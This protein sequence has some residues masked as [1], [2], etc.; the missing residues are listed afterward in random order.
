M[1]RW[2]EKMMDGERRVSRAIMALAG[3]MFALFALLMCYTALLPILSGVYTLDS[4]DKAERFSRSDF[5]DGVLPYTSSLDMMGSFVITIEVIT[6]VQESLTSQIVRVLSGPSQT[7]R[8]FNVYRLAGSG[9]SVIYLTEG[10]LD[11]SGVV[12]VQTAYRELNAQILREAAPNGSNIYVLYDAASP[13][14]FYSLTGLF[15]LLA[16]A[17]FWLNGSSFLR[18]RTNLGRRIAKE[19][20]FRELC[21]KINLQAERPLYDASGVTVLDDWVLFKDYAA[22]VKD[23]VWTTIVPASDVMGVEVAPE[24]D[25]DGD[26][27][28]SIGIK[29]WAHPYVIGLDERQAALLKAAVGE[30]NGR[31]RL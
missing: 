20:D 17:L 10:V 29:G 14:P 6:T 11:D 22:Y 8:T 19:G 5:M 15:I 1:K 18:K 13:V 25:E 24:V 28:C 23:P 16:A 12:H 26:H 3:G 4:A 27:A 21:R 7:D 30:M 31:G 2:I 9:F